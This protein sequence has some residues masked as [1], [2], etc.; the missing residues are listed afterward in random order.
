MVV[1]STWAP[2][3]ATVPLLAAPWIR[4]STRTGR[5]WLLRLVPVTCTL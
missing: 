3:N 5:P 2:S 1:T 4:R